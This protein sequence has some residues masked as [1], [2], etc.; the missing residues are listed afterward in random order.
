[1]ASIALTEPEQYVLARITEAL[2][3][4]TRDRT[5]V[6]PN[7]YQGSWPEVLRELGDVFANATANEGRYEAMKARLGQPHGA[8]IDR[9][10]E[11]SHWLAW[12]R[13]GLGAGRVQF[14][15][16]FAAG[17]QPYWLEGRFKCKKTQLYR[18]RKEVL[19]YVVLRLQLNEP[20]KTLDGGERMER[21][22]VST[23]SE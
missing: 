8:A 14:I 23:T 20:E 6:G 11:V 3:T 2:D 15:C 7:G 16:A 10:I 19:A 18:W 9:A 5:K 1:M 21:I 22:S 12:V 17:K 4:W 13:K